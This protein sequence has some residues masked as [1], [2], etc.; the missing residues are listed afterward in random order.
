MGLGALYLMHLL[1]QDYMKIRKPAAKLASFLLSKRDL[2]AVNSISVF[3]FCIT[4]TIHLFV[5][6]TAQLYTFHLKQQEFNIDWNRILKNDPLK[7]AQSL[8]C[9]ICAGAERDNKD[10]TP[11]IHLLEYVFNIFK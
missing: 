6:N 5:K 4:K 1:A 9:Q 7:C 10:V 11:I 8:I 2:D 3:Q